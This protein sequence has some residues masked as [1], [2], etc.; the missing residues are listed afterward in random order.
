MTWM[1]LKKQGWGELTDEI[2]PRLRFGVLQER[3]ADQNDDKRPEEGRAPN[4]FEDPPVRFA[5]RL[6]LVHNCLIPALEVPEGYR[7]MGR[8]GTQRRGLR[9]E[10]DRPSEHQDPRVSAKPVACTRT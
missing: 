6:V 1:S 8:R 10:E 5:A 3:F 9:R 2:P 7:S 4:D